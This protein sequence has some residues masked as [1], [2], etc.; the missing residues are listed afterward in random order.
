FDGNEPLAQDWVEWDGQGAAVV[1][2]QMLADA[3]R[4]AEGGK[5]VAR[6]KPLARSMLEHLVVTP[7][8]SASL[9]KRRLALLL[10]DPEAG[11]LDPSR[12]EHLLNEAITARVPGAALSLGRLYRDGILVPPDASAA[13]RLLTLAAATGDPRAA[14]ELADLYRRP[15]TVL[16]MPGAAEHFHMLAMISVQT[17]LVN[18][19][20]TL[21][22]DVGDFYLNQG[23]AAGAAIAGEWFAIGAALEHA[24]SELK[25][26]RLMLSGN[27]VVK[28]ETKALELLDEAAAHGSIDANTAAARVYLTSGRDLPKAV[29]MLEQARI[30]R[31]MNAYALLARFYRGDFTGTPDFSVMASVLL[32]ASELPAAPPALLADLAYAFRTGQGVERSEARAAAIMRNVADADTPE[33]HLEAGRYLIQVGRDRLKAE[34]HFRRAAEAGNPPAMAEL[35]TMLRCVPGLGSAAQATQW[36]Q[37]A[38][39]AG[40][41]ESL[42]R[43]ARRAWEAGKLEEAATLLQRSAD[44]NDRIAMVD[45]AILK[46]ASTEPDAAADA[47]R[48]RQQAL[49]NGEGV[50]AG[51][52]AVAQAL[53]RSDLPGGEAEALAQLENVSAGTDATVDTEWAKQALKG[54][55][56]SRTAAL[57]RLE[58]AAETGNPVA[59]RILAKELAGRD[60]EG[61]QRWHARAAEWGEAEALQQVVAAGQGSAALLKT[62]GDRVICDPLAMYFVAALH[63]GENNPDGAARASVLLAQAEEVAGERVADQ[64]RLG[65]ALATGTT[66]LQ[67]DPERA[68]RLLAQAVAAKHVR[69]KVLLADVWL[70]HNP[71][72]KDDVALDLLRT[73]AVQGDKMAVDHLLALGLDAGSPLREAALVAL[74]AAAGAGNADAMLG[75]GSALAM[76]DAE[77]RDEGLSFMRQSAEAGNI[78]AMKAL[79]RLYASG[80]SGQASADESTRWTRAA[81]EKGDAEAMFQ[82][83]LALDLGF[84][85]TPD[86]AAATDWHKKAREHGYV[87]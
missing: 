43:L 36:E 74:Q 62:L 66:T 60:P 29:K 48:L 27:G 9:A 34:K 30:D 25:L 82:Y 84:G 78:A 5:D 32:E 70:T 49:A 56:A 86:H 38:A 42:R 52:L 54:N 67:P 2:E 24:A 69:A 46:Q 10:L 57:E 85:V 45:L 4:Y 58:N 39:D 11:P 72:K 18:G 44:L 80:L 53:L 35:A 13:S 47:A 63:Q 16:P 23:D 87:E 8:L 7:N 55:D 28:N 41:G 14:L 37:Q 79:S 1:P 51:R 59:M 22:A 83:A 73:A 77:R 40:V 26:A 19:D 81:A 12:A 33:A 71:G 64:V 31:D 21:L 65:R 20:C 68:A 6:N 3:Q 76:T 50:V 61:A 15:D 17:A 75:L